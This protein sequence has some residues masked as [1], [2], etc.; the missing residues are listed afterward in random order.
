MP[1]SAAEINHAAHSAGV[2][3]DNFI[4]GTQPCGRSR[5]ASHDFLHDDALFTAHDRC[6]QINAKPGVAKT[7]WQQP[8]AEEAG[9]AAHG[10][11]ET[12]A[13][14]VIADRLVDADQL[15]V[16]VDQGAAA[17]AGVDGRVGLQNVVV[18]G[19]AIIQA[20][21]HGAQDA[22]G[23]AVLQAKGIP[24]SQHGFTQHQVV[25]IGKLGGLQGLGRKVSGQA[26]Q[27]QIAGSVIA[28]QHRRVAFAIPQSHLGIVGAAH[29]VMIGQHQAAGI[30][31]DAAAQRKVLLHHFRACSIESAE[32]LVVEGVIAVV[33]LDH[34]FGADIHYP[35]QD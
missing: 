17:V 18:D 8:V 32:K 22:L 33:R 20:A 12:D 7:V 34:A 6:P 13:L 25:W 14:G 19:V 24:D 4:P 9:Q 1:D 3:G 16:Q 31:N 15:A 5:T 29:Y 23:N 35:R 26:Q 21:I 10:N 28:D 11:G 27:A 30:D 2:D